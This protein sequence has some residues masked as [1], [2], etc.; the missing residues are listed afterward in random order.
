MTSLPLIRPFRVLVLAG[1]I[2]L[3]PGPLFAQTQAPA[4]AS[5][6][7]FP[8][9][10]GDFHGFVSHT[11]DLEGYRVVVVEPK[12][13]LPGNPWIWR[14]KFWEVYSE[15]DIACL[16]AGIYFVYYDVQ[17]F[18]G[19]HA[20]KHFDALYSMMTGQYGLSAKPA[21]EAISRGGLMAYWWTSA[22]PDKVGCLYGDAPVCDMNSW[23]GGKGKGQGSPGDWRE[24]CKDF[25]LSE[26]QMMEFKGSPIDA[27]APIVRAHV[28]VIH[29]CGDADK[30]VP[31]DENTDVVRERLVK[32]GGNF[33]LIVKA[34][35][36]HHPHG[37]AN[38]KPVVDFILA[39]CAT[40]EAAKKARETAPKLGAVITMPQAEWVI[41]GRM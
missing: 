3:Q 32:L 21:L 11:F 12:K 6:P 23:P 22:N 1:L 7:V 29:V 30:E 10:V 39:H 24:A 36:G 28:P 14:V 37:L 9:A 38:P 26:A 41:P 27:L 19:D 17:T 8:G 31:K 15:T 33:T 25:G 4:P 16:Q 20:L 40:G 5:A 2:L 13:P 34:G 35:C 18:A